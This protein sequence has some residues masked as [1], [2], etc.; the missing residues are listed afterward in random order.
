MF[1]SQLNILLKNII[2]QLQEVQNGQKTVFMERIKN[3]VIHTS[4]TLM[5]MQMELDVHLNHGKY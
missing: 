1:I 5:L 3:M 4:D 2:R